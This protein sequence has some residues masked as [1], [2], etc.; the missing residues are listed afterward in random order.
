M[1]N[2]L[3]WTI[4]LATM[5]V[6]IC[7][8]H[9]LEQLDSQYQPIHY[10]LYDGLSRVAWSIAL[11]YIIFACEHSAGGLVNRFLSH[12]LWQPFSRL[13]YSIYLVHIPL[14]ISLAAPMKTPFYF[15]HLS[16]LQNIILTY[17]FTV[18]ASAIATLIFESPIVTIEKLIF[19]E[20]VKVKH[21]NGTN[22]AIKLNGTN[23][24]IE[25]NGEKDKHI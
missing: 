12:Q 24:T 1:I 22:G 11:C 9:P 8:T 13:S 6:V 3:A 18:L 17:I 19:N 15:T 21:Q 25:Q 23:E 2:L 14:I 20:T 16:F 5:A 10:G 7:L 4:S